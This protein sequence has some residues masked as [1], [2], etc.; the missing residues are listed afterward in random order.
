VLDCERIIDPFL[1]FRHHPAF[2][3][4]T[5]KPIEVGGSC[6]R[7]EATGRGCV[8]STLRALEKKDFKGTARVAVQGY[9]NVG[10]I[11]AKLLHQLG[12][13]IVAASD[14]RGAIYNGDG[15]DP[16]A[17]RSHKDSTGSIVG[18]KE[19]EEI[20]ETA[21][22]EV[23]CDVLIPAALEQQITADNAP[24]IRAKII[25]EGANGP[26][27]PEAD[28]ILTENGVLLVP[29]I[30][31]NAGGVV[32]SYFEWIQGCQA[33]FWEECEVNEKLKKIID[34]A[35]DATHSL[36]QEKKT[37][38]RMAAYMLAVQ[39]VADAIRIRGIYP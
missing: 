13:K 30:L 1:E 19:T 33:Y 12:H 7:T 32:V 21:V 38:M 18:Y 22:L 2:G 20:P 35:F 39:R 3:I 34:T 6:G 16:V 4:V 11:A 15:F 14:S 23:D 26:T 31:A 10:W 8:F 36:A 29:D 9:G 28:A 27:T 17:A 37:N 5:G 25:I 24:N